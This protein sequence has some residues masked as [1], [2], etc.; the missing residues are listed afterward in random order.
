MKKLTFG[1]ATAVLAILGG[2]PCLAAQDVRPLRPGEQRSASFAGAQVRMPLGSKA[3]TKPTARLQ[4]GIAHSSRPMDFAAPPRTYRVSALELGASQT[5]KPN[6][7][8]G[9]RRASDVRKRLGAKGE[10]GTTL[11]IVG[12]VVMGLAIL[13]LIASAADD[14]EECFF[15]PCG[16]SL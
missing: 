3:A 15:G 16:S 5:G 10:S 12:G 13:A 9:R 4:L 8:A 6:L 11:L 1:G 14:D 2:Q 7:Y